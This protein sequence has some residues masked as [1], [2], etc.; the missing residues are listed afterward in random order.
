[1]EFKV[2]HL[3]LC[4][5]ATQ[6]IIEANSMEEALNKIASIHTVTA[7]CDGDCDYQIVSD[8]KTLAVNIEA[9]K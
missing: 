7:T 4:E 9:T 1:M 2:K 5:V 8:I 6:R 3:V